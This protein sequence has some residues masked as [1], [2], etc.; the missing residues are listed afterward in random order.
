[1]VNFPETKEPS[2]L[3]H[4]DYDVVTKERDCSRRHTASRPQKEVE[5]LESKEGD[6]CYEFFLETGVRREI[7]E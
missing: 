7:S 4:L 2:R 1:M 6:T 3:D 5:V